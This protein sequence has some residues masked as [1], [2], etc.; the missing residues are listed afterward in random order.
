MANK[1]PVAEVFFTEAQLR[2]LEAV[3]PAVVMGCTAPEAALRQYFGQ[4]AVLD[5]V[6]RKTRGISKQT[7]HINPD[8]IPPPR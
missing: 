7:L 3:Y 1:N 8:D 2:Y 5:T 4:Q 6:R